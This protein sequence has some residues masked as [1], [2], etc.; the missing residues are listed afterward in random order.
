MFEFDAGKVIIVG[1]VALIVIGPKDFPRVMVQLGQAAAK[2][3]RMAAEFRSQFMD[4]MRETEFEE[5]K[6]NMARLAESTKADAGIDPLGQIKAE[7]TGA[8]AAAEKPRALGAISSPAL[9]LA[10][11]VEPS[12]NA[13]DL[14]H[15]PET[16]GEEGQSGMPARSQEPP[17]AGAVDAEMRALAEA[18]AAEMGEAAPRPSQADTTAAQGKV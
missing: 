3:R 10:G 17:A 7:L 5:I 9:G 18:L 1:I 4:A 13:I 14:P 11:E 16:P 15:L 8:L 6:S 12:L 2:L